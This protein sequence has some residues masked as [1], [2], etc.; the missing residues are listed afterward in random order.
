MINIFILKSIPNAY[1]HKKKSLVTSQKLSIEYIRQVLIS[2]EMKINRDK[3]TGK[4]LEITISI[5]SRPSIEKE[6][7]IPM[8]NQSIS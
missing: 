7:A 6:T 2:E 5:R 4:L 1:D 3:K 8:D